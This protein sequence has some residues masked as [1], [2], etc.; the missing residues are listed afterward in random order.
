MYPVPSSRRQ[1]VPAQA[2][3]LIETHRGSPRPRWLV[4]GK[5]PLHNTVLIGGTYARVTKTAWAS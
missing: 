5:G 2:A 4:V 1:E 3:L